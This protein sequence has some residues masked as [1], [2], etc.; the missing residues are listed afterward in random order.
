MWVTLLTIAPGLIP[1]IIEAI[2]NVESV[3]SGVLSGTIK[4]E[5]VMAVVKAILDTRDYF[6][7]GDSAYQDM[8][9]NF[10]SEAIDF[11]VSAFN[12]LGLFKTSK[13]LDFTPKGGV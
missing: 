4:K 13:K 2:I 10:T 7:K 3:V 12:V 9:L 11:I 1:I 5:K 6:T 8:I